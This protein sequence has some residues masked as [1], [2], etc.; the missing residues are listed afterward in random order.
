MGD[1]IVD[2]HVE[3]VT[4]MTENA[5]FTFFGD[6]GKHGAAHLERGYQSFIFAQPK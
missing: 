1:G 6:T 3:K 4:N 2:K 5:F